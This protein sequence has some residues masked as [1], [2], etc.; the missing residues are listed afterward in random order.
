ML[1]HGA[2]SLVVQG[3]LVLRPLGADPLGAM[4]ARMNFDQRALDHLGTDRTLHARLT[5][6]A[7]P[8][9]HGRI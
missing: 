1:H 5:T 9:D 4:H 6:G 2:P 7:G 8:H 3:P